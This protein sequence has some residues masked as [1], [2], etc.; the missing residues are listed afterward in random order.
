[1][2]RCARHTRPLRLVVAAWTLLA[3][4]AGVGLSVLMI[5]RDN[6]Q[7]AWEQSRAHGAN[8]L[9]RLAVIVERTIDVTP[10]LVAE[11]LA[12]TA[13]QQGLEL[14]V[15][16][17]PAS[18]VVAATSQAAVGRR[19]ADA[20][21]ALARWS[22]LTTAPL[23]PRIYE[24]RRGSRLTLARTLVWPAPAGVLRG[25]GQGRLY[26]KI[27]TQHVARALAADTL[28]GHAL[29]LAI[30][31]AVLVLVMLAVDRV[32][33]RPIA[34][35]RH[36][37]AR[38]AAGELDYRIPVPGTHIRELRLLA[39]DLN[40]MASA[41]ASTVQRLSDSERG[42]RTLLAAAPE[43]IVAVDAQGRIRHY[44]CAAERLFGW[45]A[46][47]MLGATLER[48]IPAM[49]RE[50]HA[51]CFKR[52]AGRNGGEARRIFSSRQV[53]GLHRD[54]RELRLELGLSR[55]AVE[56]VALFTTLI[57]D[58][59]E[60]VAIERELEDH[61][62]NLEALVRERT[63]EV[64]RQRDRA[65]AATRAKSEFLAN[66]SHEIRTP[67]NA[68]IGLAWLA[69]REASREQIAHLDRMTAAARHL[70]AILNDILD[71]SKLE[72]GK[73][74]LAP[75]DT[76]LAE[77]LEQVTQLF[78]SPAAEKGLELIAWHAADLPAIVA[79]DDLR[80]RQVLMNLLGNA[81]KFTTRG[82]VCLR[83]QVL[84]RDGDRVR[85]RC[86]VS[87][88][89]PGI[90]AD[91]RAR[92][93]RPF[94]Q[95]DASLTRRHGGTGLGL[96]I[97]QRLLTMMGSSLEIDSTPGGGSR[98][99]FELEAQ[100][101]AEAPPAGGSTLAVDDA[102]PAT[103]EA[104]DGALRRLS[105]QRGR[106]VLVVEDIAL[107]REVFRELL[108]EAGF[109]VTI[110]AD[111]V[112]ALAALAGDAPCDLVLMDMQ[113]PQMDGLEAT[114]RIRALAHR[115]GLPI[116]ALTANAQPRDRERCRAA[117]MDDFLGKPIDFEA[118][119]RVL[120]RWLP[121]APRAAAAPPPASPP[122]RPRIE[123]LDAAIGL[124]TTRGD[125][126]AWRRLLARF[127]DAH[128]AD[129]ARLRTATPEEL[130]A[131]VHGLK[132][133]AGA[134][135]AVNVCAALAR[136]EATPGEAATMALADALEATLAA[137]GAARA[138]ED[139]TPPA[140]SASPALPELRD[141]LR[142]RLVQRDLSALRYAQVHGTA[143]RA[144]FGRDAEALIAQIE[145]FE[146]DAAL[147][148]LDA[149]THDAP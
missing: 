34:V 119:S 18:R 46:E 21:P 91:T 23:G 57:R 108:E 71:F 109:V 74:E 14:A 96:A 49:A 86:E 118:F 75:R 113:M 9:A 142:E 143:I 51:A 7:R 100:V 105:G 55:S 36:A 42:F 41:V 130:R 102:V 129:P 20:Y 147:A 10:G 124:A 82:Q 132:G 106:R 77:L 67:M 122:D 59:T 24:R 107:N 103:A 140:T 44:N 110:A 120:S 115:A 121:T 1:M 52:L 4:M 83:T 92:L 19:L 45:S 43:A 141:A 70:L 81:V 128:R 125:I 76:A 99:A 16:V 25:Q 50:T 68:I 101:R 6:G 135:G 63:A 60:R 69:R 148:S 126:A 28:R 61:R 145:N 117:G 95:G 58:V 33:L 35:L 144:A 11:L 2:R 53:T 12:H 133:T 17:D 90:D 13:V 80:V 48:L 87:D 40:A 3:L 39:E 5:V 47:E 85:L 8:E 66:M 114:R 78:T 94:E 88:T 149:S 84:A 29:D 146:F 27:D 30:F 65:E 38:L 62:N 136:A 37:S 134:V 72:A 31:A 93:C 15:V 112:E 32:V 111:G 26:L 139:A 137:I 22:E 127:A 73:L 97:C 123:G 56:G 98:F 131:L 89:G 79:L 116:V 54:G 64:V 138:T 104:F